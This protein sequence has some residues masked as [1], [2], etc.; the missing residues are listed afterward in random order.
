MIRKFAWVPATRIA[1]AALLAMLAGTTTIHAQQTSTEPPPADQSQPQTQ[2]PPAQGQSSSQES[3]EYGIRKP[4]PKDY[5]NWTFNA[6]G[7]ASLTNGTTKTYVRSG[8]GI[9]AAGVARNAN[10]YLGLRLDFQ[11][12]NLPLRTSALQLA[13]APGATDHVYALTLG[14]VINVPVNQNWGGYLIGGVGFFHRSGKLDSSSAIPGS[15]CNG[16][17]TWWGHCFNNSLPLSGN[18]LH[19]SQNDLGEDFGAG[20]TRKITPKIE[21]YAEFRYIHG[22]HANITTDFRPITVGL[23]W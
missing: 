9:I 18:F 20:V 8:G 7:G 10:K 4:K 13:Q 15:A 2:P 23:R 21:F 6:G 3:E 16:F 19:S 14:P 12:D 1:C 5:K 22:K 11:F 17:F